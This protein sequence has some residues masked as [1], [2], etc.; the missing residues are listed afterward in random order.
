V[1]ARRLHPTGGPA[2]PLTARFADAERHLAEGVALARRIGRP[3]PEFT[4]FAYQAAAAHLLFELASERGR[5]AV[6]LAEQH[7][8]SDTDGAGAAGR[9][10]VLGPARTAVPWSDLPWKSDHRQHVLRGL[11]VT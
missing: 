10:G 1:P 4:G 6:V 3:Y 8:W 9:G 11:P 7:G 2:E 5:Q